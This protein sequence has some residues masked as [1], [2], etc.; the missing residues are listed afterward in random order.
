MLLSI[1]SLTTTLTLTTSPKKGLLLSYNTKE[2]WNLCGGSHPRLAS[3]YTDQWSDSYCLT[4]QQF[5]SEHLTIRTT[6][7]NS[8]INN[9]FLNELNISKNKIKDLTKPILILDITTPSDDNTTNYRK[10]LE[11]LIKESSY[12]TITCYTDGSRTDSGVGAGFLTTT[13]NSPHNIIN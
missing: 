13:N 2:Q 6:S 11:I 7:K 1:A 8:Y 4:V 3:G 5:E 12:N 9:N 10:D